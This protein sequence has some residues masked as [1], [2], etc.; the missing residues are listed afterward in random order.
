MLPELLEGEHTA[1][2]HFMEYLLHNVRERSLPQ[3]G[4]PIH[5]EA[6]QLGEFKAIFMCHI[7]KGLQDTFI[8]TLEA[9]MGQDC[10]HCLVEKLPAGVPAEFSHRF[11][12]PAERRDMAVLLVLLQR[13][14]PSCLPRSF[15]ILVKPLAQ[16]SRGILCSY[17]ARF[18]LLL[19]RACLNNPRSYL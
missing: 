10:G 13:A 4:F 18:I 9:C 15:T 2:A 3:P 19:H 1:N 8:S 7:S 16:L 14:D 12:F 6:Q 11:P 17:R 5:S